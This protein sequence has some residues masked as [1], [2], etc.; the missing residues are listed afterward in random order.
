MLTGKSNYTFSNLYPNDFVSPY[1]CKKATST[2]KF[3]KKYIVKFLKE[4]TVDQLKEK[5][6]KIITQLN[7]VM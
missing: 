2:F 4:S 1:I 3:L 7:Y 6:R 5:Y